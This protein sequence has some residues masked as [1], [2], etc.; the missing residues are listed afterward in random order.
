MDLIWSDDTS[1]NARERLYKEK[2]KELDINALKQFYGDLIQKMS[3]NDFLRR[4]IHSFNASKRLKPLKEE[5]TEE[6]LLELFEDVIQPEDMEQQEILY[7]NLREIYKNMMELIK[8]SKVQDIE[9][10]KVLLGKE[11]LERTPGGGPLQV[12]LP[13][14]EDSYFYMTEHLND[15]QKGSKGGRKPTDEEKK[16]AFDQNMQTISLL[17]K[18]EQLPEYALYQITNYLVN[19]LKESDEFKKFYNLKYNFERPEDK[20]DPF[21]TQIKESWSILCNSDMY[22]RLLEVA[23]H[24]KTPIS[25]LKEIENLG[26]TLYL[27]GDIQSARNFS[28]EEEGHLHELNIATRENLLSRPEIT[29]EISAKQKME[30][31]KSENSILSEDA[32]LQTISIQGIEVALKDVASHFL[33]QQ[34]LE[35]FKSIVMQLVLEQS[36]EEGIR[37][38]TETI[39]RAIT[40]MDR[41]VKGMEEQDISDETTIESSDKD[42][43]LTGRLKGY[44]EDCNRNRTLML[45]EKRSA[46]QR[47]LDMIR[48]KIDELI[49]GKKENRDR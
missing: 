48:R 12:E 32:D 49:H 28:Y 7:T 38:V 20:N 29:R 11:L 13:I 46:G 44:M 3:T 4:A 37:S 47:F 27:A 19:T 21:Y 45:S 25:S 41:S 5:P 2:G 30:E 16:E 6:E 8:L 40:E 14:P 10:R 34:D 35:S 42:R 9:V 26:R 15:E 24:Q 17:L 31:G 43:S 22:K 36:T 33:S 1:T 23:K 39:Q 18:N